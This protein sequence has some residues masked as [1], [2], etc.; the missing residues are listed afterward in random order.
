MKFNLKANKIDAIFIPIIMISALLLSFCLYYIPKDE[1]KYVSIYIQ[2]KLEYYLDLNKN[3]TLILIKGDYDKEKNQFPSL[4][5]DMTIEIKDK[6]V[7]V[8]KEESPLHI[9]SK[10]GWISLPNMPITCA[11]NAVIIVIESSQSKDINI[12][13]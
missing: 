9:C 3:Q 6:K 11:P 12:I 10:Q 8:E 5:G 13:V 2:T 1:G 4:K 7:R